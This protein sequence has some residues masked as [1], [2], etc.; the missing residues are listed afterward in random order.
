VGLT[1]SIITDFN[2][3]ISILDKIDIKKI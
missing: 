2:L 1:S 3:I